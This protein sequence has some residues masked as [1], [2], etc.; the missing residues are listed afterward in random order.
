MK[1]IERYI[2]RRTLNLT[3]ASLALV[4]FIVLTTQ[5]LLYLNI[6]TQSGQSVAT[7]LRLAFTLVPVRD[8]GVIA[9]ARINS[10]GWQAGMGGAV[11]LYCRETVESGHGFHAR[12]FSPRLGVGEDPATGSAVAALAGAIAEFDQPPGGSHRYV[13]EQGFEMGRPSLIGLEIDMD[14]GAVVEGRIS[15]EA[16]VFAR[17]TIET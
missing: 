11:Y 5:S 9:R 2:F 12:M 10:S 7:F 1:L 16:V 17:G 14:G 8:L 13:V 15:G 4:T 6:V 3:L